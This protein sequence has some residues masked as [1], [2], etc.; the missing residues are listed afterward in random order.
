MNQVDYTTLPLEELK[1][2]GFMRWGRAPI[3]NL[4]L[5]PGPLVW[6]A[7]KGQK[8]YGIDGNEYV[9]GIQTLDQ[10]L[11]FGY[12]AYGVKVESDTGPIAPELPPEKMMEIGSGRMKR[13]IRQSAKDRG[14]FIPE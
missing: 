14:M 8:L 11:L 12:L 1:K 7:L 6:H 13:L 4:W 5:M 10:T 9:F 3:A 2:L